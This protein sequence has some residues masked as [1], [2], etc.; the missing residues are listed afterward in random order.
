MSVRY[1]ISPIVTNGLVLYLD[2]ANRQSYTSGSTSWYDATQNGLSGS[3]INGPTFSS[4]NLGSIVFD[5]TNDYVTFS[6]SQLAPG[7]GSFTWNFWAKTAPSANNFSIVF[8]GTGSNSFYGVISMDLRPGNGL[9][10]YA[11]GFRIQDYNTSFGTNWWFISFVGNGG[12]NG[13]RNLKLYRNT[14]QAGSTYTYDYDFTSINPNIGAN[15]SAYSELMTGNIASVSYYN[16]ALTQA[17]I[18]QNYNATKARYG[19]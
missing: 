4:A 5:G 1:A 15:H 7:T 17:E 18:I 11:N 9:I 14:V 6:N 2:A 10:Y 16:Q 3:L 19:L 12:N 13:S 8:S